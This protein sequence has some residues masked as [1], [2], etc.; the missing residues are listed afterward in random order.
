MAVSRFE[1]SA[2]KPINEDVARACGFLELKGEA[3]KEVI[4]PEISDKLKATYVDRPDG[5]VACGCGDDRTCSH[6]SSKHIRQENGVNTQGAILRYFGGG[7]GAA[8]I[9]LVTLAAQRGAEGLAAFAGRDIFDITAELSQRAKDADNV[10]FALHSSTGS[11]HDEAKLNPDSEDPLA[12]AYAG[13]LGGVSTGSFSGVV[14]AASLAE[15]AS[16]FGQAAIG[17]YDGL[18]EA[19]RLFIST[20]LDGREN[21]SA[22]REDY[23]RSGVPVMLLSGNHVNSSQ[24]K[25]V[26]NYKIDKLS[27]PDLAHNQG[28]PFYNNDVTQVAATII[29]SYPE[30]QFDP[31]T[32]LMAMDLDIR[33]TRAALSGGNPLDL[34]LARYGDAKEALDYLSNL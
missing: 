19:N 12:C 32:M 1:K 11:E 15:G 33:S 27:S 5:P 2:Q 10:V 24:T 16:L 6:A 7:L 18:A 29:K 34:E 9:M 23:I 26:T 17:K 13:S 8:R 25:S 4:V 14:L 22:T 3:V 31:L 21:F 28:Y 30:H 20:T